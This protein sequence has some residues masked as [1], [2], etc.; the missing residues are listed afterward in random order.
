VESIVSIISCKTARCPTGKRIA[1]AFLFASRSIGSLTL[2][3]STI[4][5]RS[6]KYWHSGMLHGKRLAVVVAYDMYLEVASG[7]LGTDL[8]TSRPVDFHRFREKLAIQMLQYSPSN[9][10]YPGDDRFRSVTQVPKQR[11]MRPPR[12]S[13][14][15]NTSVGD[16]S[17]A[18]GS[19]GKDELDKASGRLCGFLD[20]LLSHEASVKSIPNKGHAVCL[21]CGKQAYSKCFL[22]PEKPAL[23]MTPPKGRVNSCFLHYHNTASFGKWR[24]DYKTTGNKRPAEWQYPDDDDLHQHSQAMQRLHTALTPAPPAA[25]T[26]STAER[27]SST[28][29]RR[30][31]RNTNTS[32]RPTDPDWNDNCI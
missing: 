15:S 1:E 17:S 18:A 19:I 31:N 28:T 32:N 27:S 4:A 20:E 23:H 11:R 12:S 3:C 13:S 16:A 8:K 29:A 10:K 7:T 22:C 24:R 26:A 2:C 14:S 21:C 30:A 6:W 5:N 25:A 9:H